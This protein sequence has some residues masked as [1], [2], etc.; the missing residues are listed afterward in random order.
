[1]SENFINTA[2]TL[3]ASAFGFEVD[4]I[5]LF[6][7]EMGFDG[8]KSSEGGSL[9]EQLEK[10]NRIESPISDPEYEAFPIDGLENLYTS[11]TLPTVML[12]NKIAALQEQQQ[13]VERLLSEFLLVADEDS[14]YV[15]KLISANEYH[16]TMI[17]GLE[18][19]R[20]EMEALEKEVLQHDKLPDNTDLDKKKGAS[21]E[22]LEK[23]NKQKAFLEEKIQSMKE[24]VRAQLKEITYEGANLSRDG[25]AY[26][27]Y[28]R[29]YN[30]LLS[31]TPGSVIHPHPET[32]ELI[33][34]P[35]NG[36]E[37]K[38][39]P[40]LV[41]Y[42]VGIPNELPIN[43]SYAFWKYYQAVGGDELKIRVTEAYALTAEHKSVA[44]REGLAMDF[45][46]TFPED[47]DKKAEVLSKI[48]VPED[49]PSNVMVFYEIADISDEELEILREKVIEDLVERGYSESY[50]RQLVEGDGRATSGRVRRISW[51][52]GEHFHWEIV[53][54][55]RI[56]NIRTAL[57]M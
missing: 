15:Q 16:K 38:G 50:A 34:Y 11:E 30:F 46:V 52:T 35:L 7:F 39:L 18:E 44:H 33:W 23:M 43:T 14:P 54:K 53:G 49:G 55:D 47:L 19:L 24:G 10:L 28:D 37:S 36:D 1:M 17:A 56:D 9:K 22:A 48:L 6:D 41:D 57:K 5:D 12:E 29:A 21:S 25:G 2:I 40:A 42:K 32:G 8:Q 27:D 51:A 20:D 45:T 31:A 13:Y 3:G 4:V 26:A